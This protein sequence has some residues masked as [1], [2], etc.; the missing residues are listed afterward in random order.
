MLLESHRLDIYCQAKPNTLPRLTKGQRRD[1]AAK[2]RASRLKTLRPD[3]ATKVGER[4]TVED[5]MQL[6]GYESAQEMD[7]DL[8]QRA[9]RISL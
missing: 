2:D 7:S 5:A 8:A 3:I 1:R 6:G 4:V 9:R